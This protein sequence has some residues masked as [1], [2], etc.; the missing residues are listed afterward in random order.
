[1]ILRLAELGLALNIR[2][3]LASII[4]AAALLPTTLVGHAFWTKDCDG[5]QDQVVHFVKNLAVL[6]GL[7]ALIIAVR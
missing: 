6:G 2:P 4:L 3:A 7:M 1:M 5:R